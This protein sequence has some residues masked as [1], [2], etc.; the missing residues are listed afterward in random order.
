MKTLLQSSSTDTVN[1]S[2]RHFIIG[3]AAIASGGFAL[4]L[5]AFG[6]RDVDAQGLVTVALGDSEV[7]AWVVIKPDDTCII[8]IARSEMGQGTRTG[9]AQLVTEE[10]ECDWAK[11][12]TVYPSPGQSYARKRA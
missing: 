5:T 6:A 4:G 11:V 10:L 3:S 8:R 9:L 7:T 2:R 1:P 12:A